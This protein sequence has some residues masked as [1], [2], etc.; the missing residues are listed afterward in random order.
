MVASLRILALSAVVAGTAALVGGEAAVAQ[1]PRVVALFPGSNNVAL[2]F[3]SGTS[4]TA[5]VA[6]VT[7]P[8][9][10][11]A[12]CRLDAQT[13]VFAG[14]SPAAPQ[15]SDLRTLVF[16]DAVF[17]CVNQQASIGMPGVSEPVTGPVP[18]P[19]AAPSPT[20][21]PAPIGTGL[22]LSREDP[23][24]RG[25]SLL[26]PEGWQIAVVNFIPDATQI[27][28]AQN[29]FNEPP[30]AGFKYVIVRVRGTNVSAGDPARFDAS[31]A[32]RLV[33]SRNVVYDTFTR[34][35]GVVPDEIGFDVPSEAFTGG[36]V[37]G[38][39]CFQVGADETGLVLFTRFFLS[40]ES[41]ARYF[42]VE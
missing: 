7:P 38:N 35:C 40:D 17:I 37:E 12:M 32:L 5:V 11:E 31:F 4:T 2:T 22:G 9:A 10:V 27:V 36:V 8:G 18:T 6:Q 28:L 21:A 25:Q 42:A 3:S 20:Q 16:L 39:Q 41:D 29:P 14:Y 34:G 24:P 26:V 15:A 33:G 13:S 19:P 23:V 30:D 1:P